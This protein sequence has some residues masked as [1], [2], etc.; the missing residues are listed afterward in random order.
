VK[1]L[2]KIQTAKGD[3][4]K[5]ENFTQGRFFLA[6]FLV[7][8]PTCGVH[9]NF[10]RK[11]P[12]KTLAFIDGTLL[13]LGVV[14]CKTK[15]DKKKIDWK[16]FMTWLNSISELSDVHYYNT[17]PSVASPGLESF[18]TF[19]ERELSFQ[20]HIAPLKQKKKYCPYCKKD[21]FLDEASSISVPMTLHL[22]KLA[23]FYDQAIIVAGSGELEEVIRTIR[24]D[25]VKKVTVVC[26]NEIATSEIRSSANKIELLDANLSH[27]MT[28]NGETRENERI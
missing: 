21:F 11:F 9:F 23:N 25:L 22:Y 15:D 17:A 6:L 24:Y 18:Y 2:R 3:S 16:L 10:F 20:L 12:M 5:N 13:S 26:W 8:W 27:F 28:A 1:F 19:L 7:E 14:S 4:T